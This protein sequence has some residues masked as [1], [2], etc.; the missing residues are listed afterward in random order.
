MLYKMANETGNHPLWNEVK[1]IDR[2]SHWYA[3]RVKE[4]IHIRPYP[5]DIHRDNGIE[6]PEAWIPTIKKHNRRP[7]LQRTTRTTSKSDLSGNN[8]TAEQWGSKR[9]NHSPP[10]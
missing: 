6:I 2:D 8:F 10:S 1:F 7:L 3:H 9:T 4:A 5:D